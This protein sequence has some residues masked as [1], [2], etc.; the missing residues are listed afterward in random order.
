[1]MTITHT[2]HFE[3]MA[4]TGIGLERESATFFGRVLLYLGSDVLENG[5]R[6]MREEEGDPAKDGTGSCRRRNI[7]FSTLGAGTRVQACEIAI[8][9]DEAF[10]GSGSP[11]GWQVE[12]YLI[13]SDD[14]Y[15]YETNDIGPNFFSIPQPCV[16][17]EK[18]MDGGSFPGW[19]SG[20]RPN[21]CGNCGGSGRLSPLLGSSLKV[22]CDACY[23]SGDADYDPDSV[24]VACLDCYPPG[25]ATQIDNNC[26]TCDGDG[27]MTVEQFRAMRD[28]DERE[29]CDV[30]GGDPES[31]DC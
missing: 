1:M 14:W 20:C 15:R 24:L 12:R 17:P 5:L 8:W 16:C 2:G 3:T 9:D 19:C 28:A 6:L 26:P 18:D 25:D 29:E 27:V 13:V 21:P 11:G 23:G 22:D 30:H 4:H 10:P 7:L 31:C